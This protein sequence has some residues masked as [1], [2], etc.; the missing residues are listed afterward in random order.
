MQQND[1]ISIVIPVYNAEKK[2]SRC[3]SSVL[4]QKYSNIEVILI[5][6]GSKDNSL[7]IAN[8]WEKK[9]SRIKVISKE[10]GGVSSAR[11]KG[12]ANSKGD[13]IMF[14]DAD[15]W[16]S[17]NY[18]NDMIRAAQKYKADMVICG[19][20]DI[21]DDSKIVH[22]ALY[23]SSLYNKTGKYKEVCM[24]LIKT[25]MSNS[26]CN[27]LFRKCKI[28]DFFNEERSMGEDLEFNLK[29]IEKV[30]EVVCINEN[31]YFYD[32]TGCE[33]LTHCLD[34][35][36]KSE[37]DNIAIKEAFIRK[38]G[39][40]WMDFTNQYYISFFRLLKR[41]YKKDSSYSSLKI[42]FENLTR[43]CGYH[44]IATQKVA[45]GIKCKFIR[46]C[47]RKSVFAPVYLM[48]KIKERN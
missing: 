25:G 11:N 33:S 12:I 27:K 40:E 45:Y 9:D 36:E 2:L 41:Q 5:D 38:L 34:L 14:V 24:D 13:Y 46:I 18:C 48:I 42:V 31:L 4:N 29:Y 47:I 10:N 20:V 26:P 32:K 37:I 21:F 30:N 1:L 22:T 39:M 19:F 35:V 17:D 16:V 3:I 6:D 15:D 28:Q 43:N 8:E 7:I 44:D 23:D